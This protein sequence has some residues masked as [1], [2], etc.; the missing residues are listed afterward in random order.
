MKLKRRY[1][2]ALALL[3]VTAWAHSFTLGTLAIGHAWV[4]PTTGSETEAMM[5]IA[6]GGTSGDA[7][8]GAKSVVADHIEFRGDKKKFEKFD[9]P[10]GRPMPMRP[11][12]LHLV[13]VGLKAPVVLGTKVPITLVFEKAG[14][15]DIEMFVENTPGE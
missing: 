8:I 9:V 13:L 12:G 4:R 11:K 3:P 15:I 1:I 6:N 7:L 10:V 5:P 14:S 2:L